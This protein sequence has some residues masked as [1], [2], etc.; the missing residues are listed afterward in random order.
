MSH[1]LPSQIVICISALT[2][3]VGHSA[4]A[5]EMPQTPE[6]ARF[7]SQYCNDCHGK[8]SQEG[9]L[10]IDNLQV[11]FESPKVMALWEEIMMRTV[12]GEMPPEGESRPNP[13]EVLAISE[14][15]SQ[16]VREAN[17]LSMAQKRETVQ[18]HRLSR[19]EYAYSIRD[20]MGISPYANDPSGL[21]EDPD[22]HGFERLGS[23]LTIAPS[24]IEKYVTIASRILD[25]SLSL[26]PEP[27]S[28]VITW[29]P[30]EI[31]DNDW[32]KFK[33]EYIQ[34]GIAD[35][36]RVDIVPNNGQ[37]ESHDLTLKTSGRYRVRVKLS[38]L[39]PEGGRAPR[40]QIYADGIEQLICDQDVEAP[41]DNP[42]YLEFET[43]LPAGKQQ[44]RIINAVPGPNYEARR[45]R[46]GNTPNVFT[47]L[48]ARTPW[49]LKLTDD[50]GDPLYPILLLDSIE[51]EGP[52]YDTWPTKA[53]Q[54][55]FFS[56]DPREVLSQFASRAWRRPATPTEADELVDLYQKIR[57]SGETHEQAIKVGLVAVLC[58]KNFIYLVEGQPA[59]QRDYVSDA[60]LAS[61]LSY[62]LWS[63]IPDEELL[64][65]ATNDT[66]HHSGQLRVQVRRMLNDPKAKRFATTF[67]HQWLQLRKV[68]MFT[69]DEE[70][71]PDY[72]G[73]LERS[74]I[75]ETLSFF[76]E[77]L[78]RNDSIKEF[79]D[80]DWTM[81]NERLAEFYQIDGI[82]GDQMRRV[83]LST[84]DR[85]GGLLTHASILGLTSD[86]TRHRPVHRGVWLLE[87]ILARPPQPPP[88]NV[89]ALDDAAADLKNMG[90]RQQLEL[91]RSNPNC[92]A[93]HRKID[94]LGFA[95]DHYD[96]IG[97][98]REMEV[99]G[100]AP[101]NLAEIDAS[102]QLPDGRQFSDVDGLKKLLLSDMDEFAAAFLEKLATYAL[103]RP[104]TFADREQI[105]ELVPVC[106]EHD[107]RIASMI[108]VL[109]CS[110]L[111]RQ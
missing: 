38:G 97:R 76:Q 102:G 66:L 69:P 39:R 55:I 23:V 87:S 45:S 106:R 56:D 44:I 80:S 43:Y 89:P 109:V 35:Q 78:R 51:W 108:E 47:R 12:S 103:R 53:H 105:A 16:Q 11:D 2:L 60:E 42:I 90:I 25:E 81:L 65:L 31:R 62:F 71:Y 6:I 95:L 46:S 100:K 70:L 93:C 4:V 29:T 101:N 54:Q 82:H 9:D 15:V 48:D 88:A 84:D 72:D 57:E 92:T 75:N 96:A 73:V 37:L 19:E 58:S 33:E 8:E 94:P 52:I 17:A 22:W 10:R 34:R 30:W 49:Q 104:M 74:M 32:K 79:L 20:L 13:A 68:G 67:P 64:N 111:F 5:G 28:K 14:W 98:W 36:A 61:R 50:N 26:G 86:G 83:A 91:H 3:P 63:S 27:K 40:L 21:P 85:R 24:H 18:F 7:F 41:E 77:V 99:V 1:L 110:E 107:Y 59:Q